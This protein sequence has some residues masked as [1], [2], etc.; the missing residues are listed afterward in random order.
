MRNEG[1]ERNGPLLPIWEQA[2]RSTN[3][4]RR[5]S[6]QGREAM[7]KQ[8]LTEAEAAMRLTSEDVAVCKSMGISAREFIA[9]RDGRADEPVSLDADGDETDKPE[10]FT[11]CSYCAAKHEVDRHNGDFADC[12]KCRSA[13]G[14]LPRHADPD[15]D[16]TELDTKRKLS[17]EQAAV[18]RALSISDKEFG[19]HL[20]RQKGQ[21]A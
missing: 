17:P 6:R 8:I 14:G 2:E 21:A 20:R 9:T 16:S 18:N 10:A 4:N 5:V 11:G 15:S 1:I 19:A 7:G 12:A 13:H 3:N